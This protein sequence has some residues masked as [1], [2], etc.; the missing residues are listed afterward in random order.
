MDGY[1]ETWSAQ[2]FMPKVDEAQCLLIS[3]LPRCPACGSIA[4]PNILMFGDWGWDD[5]KTEHQLMRL[6]AWLAGVSK[7]VIIEIG[8]GKNIPTIRN[9]SERQDGK[10]IRINPT[11]YWLRP[12]KGV[13]LKMGGLDALRLIETEMKNVQ[14]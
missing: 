10:V 4:R 5:G 3:E 13:S 11:D 9:W 6:N 7:L 1:C 8:A 2:T 14:I 12:G